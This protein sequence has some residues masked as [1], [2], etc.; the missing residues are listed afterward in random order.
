MTHNLSLGMLSSRM[1]C[2]NGHHLTQSQSFS[3]KGCP[4]EKALFSKVFIPQSDSDLKLLP[5]PKL[6]NSRN[7]T[8][9][10]QTRRNGSR[11]MGTQGLLRQSIYFY[12]LPPQP[13]KNLPMQFQVTSRT[14]IRGKKDLS[15]WLLSTWYF[16]AL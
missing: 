2:M 8:L 16:S 10:S 6:P 1:S 9:L 5:E 4:S 7:V 15:I 11:K 3:Y 14:V 12:V 13:L